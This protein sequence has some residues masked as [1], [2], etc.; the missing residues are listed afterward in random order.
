MQGDL[1]GRGEGIAAVVPKRLP[2]AWSHGDPIHA[3]ICNSCIK[4]NGKTNCINPTET[5]CVEA[6]GTGTVTSD[7]VE[8]QAVPEVFCK[9]CKPG[10]PLYL[11]SIKSN[12]GHLGS[13]SGPAGL[14]KAIVLLENNL[15]PP[16]T[17]SQNSRQ[18]LSL[19]SHPISVSSLDAAG[20]KKLFMGCR[21]Q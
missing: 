12:I 20:A 1:D 2:D 15:V 9:K 13:S 7:S 5:C 10:N 16:D 11:G 17:D 8:L 18:A 4:Q 3:R 21:Y 14:I 6:Y 19:L